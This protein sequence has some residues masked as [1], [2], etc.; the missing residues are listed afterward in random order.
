MSY[1]ERF[2]SHAERSKLISRHRLEKRRRDADRIKAVLLSDDGW[3][4]RQISQALLLDEQTVSRHVEEYVAQQ[5]LSNNSG[6][7]S[8]KLNAT[9]A[10]ELIKHIEVETYVK[11]KDIC[12]YVLEHYGVS[13]TEAGMTHWLHAHGFSY[14]KPKATPLK[15]SHELQKEFVEKYAD[16][17]QHTSE[18]E[19]ILFGDGVHP[20][21]ATKITYGWIRTGVDKPIATVASRTRVNLMGTINLQTMDVIAEAYETIDSH[22]MIKYFDLLK[23]QYKDAP[24]IHLIIDR[25]PYN[26]SFVTKNAAKERNIIL[27]YLPPYSP[28]LNPIERLWKVMNEYVRNNY[29]F[30]SA[31]EFRQKIMDFFKVT[32][33][34]ISGSMVD[35]I[36][37]NFQTLIPIV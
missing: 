14:K 15:A 26:I 2:L 20:T 12:S 34:K 24:K 32:W 31:K 6:G 27:H 37:D 10:Q 19:P 35:R 8:S 4:Y 30:E 36:N 9:L 7:S 25:G 18:D 13:Y 1:M 22:S 5:K 29:V 3:S 33:P 23:S 28:N 16:L 17:L 21:M 11:V